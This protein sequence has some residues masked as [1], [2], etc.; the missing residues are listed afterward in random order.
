MAQ[1]KA[2]CPTVKEGINP[3]TVLVN[4]SDKSWRTLLASF[5]VRSATLHL[6]FTL[7]KSVA[8]ESPQMDQLNH[9][10]PSNIATSSKGIATK[11][12]RRYYGLL[13]LL[14]GARTLLGTRASLLVACASL[15]ISSNSHFCL[16]QTAC[17]T[18]TATR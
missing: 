9:L 2:E 10:E 4:C 13:A 6:L 15:L 5:V 3:I 18:C 12:Q 8:G 14:L 17:S 16:Q 1:R 11:E 7:F